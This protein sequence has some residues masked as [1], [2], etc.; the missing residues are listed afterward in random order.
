VARQSQ[1]DG[2]VK[3]A[4]AYPYANPGRSFVQ[5][6]TRALER[7][8]DGA[9]RRGRSTL[10]AFGANAA[11][12]ALAG[13]LAPLADLPLPLIRAELEDF[14][15]VHSAHVSPYGA[16][17]ATL[18]RSP[19]T[20]AAVF[21]AYPT[22]EQLR[23]LSATEPNYEL[24]RLEGIRCRLVD[25]TELARLD[26][27][28]SRHGCLCLE[29]S[30][31]ALAAVDA[32]RRVFPAMDQPQVQRAVRDLLAPGLDLERFIRGCLDHDLTRRRTAALA[33]TAIPLAP[34]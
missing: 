23:L 6:G 29:G 22:P 13:K 10:L 24:R 20:L 14:D 12:A 4:L 3:R 5:L 15:V 7:S 18:Q 25:G 1:A 28:L 33:A 8:P 30:E 26:A 2:I 11:P 31:A 32:R 34:A 16:I 27:Y 9:E 21:V 19:G 17:P